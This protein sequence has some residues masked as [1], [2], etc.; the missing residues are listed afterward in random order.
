MS[1]SFSVPFTMPHG[2]IL[3]G[4]NGTSIA[5]LQEQFG[6]TITTVNRPKTSVGGIEQP[7][8][9]FF[10]I[11]GSD[12]LQVN[13]VALKIFTLL[14]ESMARSEKALKHETLLFKK[15]YEEQSKLHI[16]KVD[17]MTKQILSL[18]CR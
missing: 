14:N 12:E 4:Q 5:Q 16:M 1:F 18:K 10:N 2:S 9:P 17:E 7:I 3:D 11:E 15:A 8:I 13:R 6:C